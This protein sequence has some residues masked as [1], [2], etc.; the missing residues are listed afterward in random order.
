[1]KLSSLVP[2]LFLA[3]LTAVAS[4]PQSPISPPLRFE[5][6]PLGNVVR[7]LSARFN[8]PVTVVA[9]ASAP[10]T[11]DFSALDFRHALTEA[12]RQAGLVVVPVGSD[13]AA[14][15][16]L[17]PPGDPGSPVQIG[18]KP[19]L[20][21]GGLTPVEIVTGLQAAA[22]RRA[23]LLRQRAALVGQAAGAEPGN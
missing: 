17:E 14:G 1:M 9:H 16:I 6:M 19:V 5:K 18:P 2:A 7:V 10:V 11:G 4:E 22:D 23:E 13:A 21:A 12:A 8:A 3:A 20:A 15:F